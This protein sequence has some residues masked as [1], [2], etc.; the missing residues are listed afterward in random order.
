[1]NPE[2]PAVLDRY[3]LARDGSHVEVQNHLGKG[4]CAL[5]K[6]IDL[7]LNGDTTVIKNELLEYLCDTGR[8]L[9][10]LF[11]RE[12][13][14]RRNLIYPSLNKKVKEQVEICPPSSFLFGD[15][16]G[17]K[18]KLAKNLESVTKDLKLP[19]TGPP[20]GPEFK[21]STPG[22]SRGRDETIQGTAFEGSTLDKEGP[23]EPSLSQTTEGLISRTPPPFIRKPYPGGREVIRE[24]FKRKGLP[25]NA[26][27]TIF[28]S[29]A[30]STVKQYNTTLKLWWE[31]CEE[32]K[33]SPYEGE[34]LK[35]I[36]FLQNL[37]ET[38]ENRYGS[39]NSHRAALTLI[40]SGNISSDPNL[41]RFLKGIS[42]I[43]PQ[44][45]RYEATW[46]P[47]Q[48]LKFLGST[49]DG[50]LKQL[51]QKLVTLL[52][53]ATGQRIISFHFISFYYL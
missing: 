13:V 21:L 10:N 39:F 15:D 4:L 41:K 6:G 2:I 44:R 48:V 12:S 9:T 36:S 5:G 52:A 16:L 20:S 23:A 14:T 53:L 34:V 47:Q 1:M 18:I 19:A 30:V 35:I 17:E 49:P 26:I 3:N 32:Q 50:N 43:R 22:P 51:L 31:F 24:A 42:R 37:L 45:P 46:D 33:I 7:L 11:H 8:I 29:L 28:S 38:T 40:T 27:E 25:D